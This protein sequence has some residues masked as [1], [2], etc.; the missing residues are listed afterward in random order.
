[1]QDNPLTPKEALLQL[2]AIN[3]MDDTEIA[4]DRADKV[5]INLLNGLG[6]RDVTVAWDEIEKWYA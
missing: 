4:H 5:L 1:M 3:L 6:Y 2:K